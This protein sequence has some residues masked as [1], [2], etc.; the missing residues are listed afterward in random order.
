MALILTSK[1]CV[2]SC[3][4]QTDVKDA[5]GIP[6]MRRA[7]RTIDLVKDGFKLPVCGVHMTIKY[8]QL[9]DFSE[10]DAGIVMERVLYALA[11]KYRLP[12]ERFD[13]KL[14]NKHLLFGAE[15]TDALIASGN[16]NAAI[17]REASIELIKGM[18]DDELKIMA[19]RLGA[20][21]E[22]MLEIG[23]PRKSMEK[24]I[25]LACGIEWFDKAPAKAITKVLE[26]GKK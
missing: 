3:L 21:N 20:I 8:G 16:I 2:V 11:R 9:I 1:T 4:E 26:E 7:Q 25:C 19:T 22:I 12:I 13:R 23:V 10:F 6:V 17:Q 14:H 18:T 24:A 5:S 15:S